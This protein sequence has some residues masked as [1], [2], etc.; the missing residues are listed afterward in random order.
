M[1]KVVFHVSVLHRFEA[2]SLFVQKFSAACYDKRRVSSVIERTDSLIWIPSSNSGNS[3]FETQPECLLLWRA[4]SLTVF[5]SPPGECCRW[6]GTLN[7]PRWISS[8]LYSQYLLYSLLC[9]LVSL[10][11]PVSKWRTFIA[12]RVL[13]CYWREIGRMLAFLIN[14]Y[15]PKALL[16]SDHFIRIIE[17]HRKTCSWP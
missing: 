13:R 12:A 14:F 7:R 3:G 17:H 11:A 9:N 4:F 2:L 5:L 10:D 6:N 8:F 16:R 15:C 1:S